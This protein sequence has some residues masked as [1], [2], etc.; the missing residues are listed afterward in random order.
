MAQIS[1]EKGARVSELEMEAAQKEQEKLERQAK[2]DA[3]KTTTTG[4]GKTSC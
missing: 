4:N 1:R 3:K 2:R